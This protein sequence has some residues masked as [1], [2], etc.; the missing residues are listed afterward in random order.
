LNIPNLFAEIDQFLTLR[1]WSCNKKWLEI[2]FD[3]FDGV[4]EYLGDGVD[5]SCLSR[6]GR[7]ALGINFGRYHP[8]IFP[9]LKD[10][11]KRVD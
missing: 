5:Y 4:R 9:R 10:K 11:V 1:C 7:V 8:C 2:I 6:E 3:L